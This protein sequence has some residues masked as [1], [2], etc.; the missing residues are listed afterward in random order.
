[1]APRPS[2]SNFGGHH[3]CPRGAVPFRARP[4]PR[5]PLPGLGL[6]PAGEE[7]VLSAA[8]PLRVLR[9]SRPLPE[10]MLC[11]LVGGQRLER[12]PL[13]AHEPLRR[14]L[15]R[16]WHGPLG[17]GLERSLSAWACPPHRRGL[18]PGPPGD[19]ACHCARAGIHLHLLRHLGRRHDHIRL[20][21]FLRGYALLRYLDGENPHPQLAM[22]A[23]ELLYCVARLHPP[24]GHFFPASVR[25]VG[26]SLRH[27]LHHQEPKGVGGRDHLLFGAHLQPPGL[28]AGPGCFLHSPGHRIGGASTFARWRNSHMRP[29]P[30]TLHE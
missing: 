7:E 23:L 14:L 9:Q 2:R 10:H 11:E 8:G 19:L 17:Q 28:G 13:G 12:E 21:P 3:C 4:L 29:A 1:M 20:L 15:S 22:A 25:V 30:A 24:L 27:H 26:S 5:R 18:A 6:G 16:H